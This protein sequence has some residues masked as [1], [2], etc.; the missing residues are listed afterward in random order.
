MKSGLMSELHYG[1][2]RT[3]WKVEYDVKSDIEIGISHDH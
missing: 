3:V 2:K 1:G